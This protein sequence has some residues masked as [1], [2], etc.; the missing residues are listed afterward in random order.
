MLG[1]IDMWA[2]IR[3]AGQEWRHFMVPWERGD[4]EGSYRM[5]IRRDE[6]VSA[7]VEEEVLGPGRRS[8]RDRD[9]ESL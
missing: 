6:N 2:Y 3:A 9:R 8:V 1:K 5:R 4:W 7:R